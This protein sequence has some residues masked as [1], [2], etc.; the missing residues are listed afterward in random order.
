MKF[1]QEHPIDCCDCNDQLWNLTNS[2]ICFCLFILLSPL[3][4][5][6]IISYSHERNQTAEIIFSSSKNTSSLGSQSK[7][8]SVILSKID[9]GSH[10]FCVQTYPHVNTIWLN[11]FCNLFVVLINNDL[12]RQRWGLV[13]AQIKAFFSVMSET[14][15]LCFSAH[16]FPRR[17]SLVSST[18]SL[19]RLMRLSFR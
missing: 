13:L 2:S 12:L 11:F 5:I 10:P 3:C 18:W 8:R 15:A 1:L 17:M 16:C 9:F 6:L 19:R 14:R 4:V 7:R